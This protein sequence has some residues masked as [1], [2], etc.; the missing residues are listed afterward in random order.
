MPALWRRRR[1][2]RAIAAKMRRRIAQ[3][4]NDARISLPRFAQ[5]SGFGERR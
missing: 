4:E 2:M 3:T 1:V 5:K